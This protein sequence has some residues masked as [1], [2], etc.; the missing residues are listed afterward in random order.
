MTTPERPPRHVARSRRHGARTTLV[1]HWAPPS[2]PAPRRVASLRPIRLEP[3][4]ANGHGN[5]S[6]ADGPSAQGPPG[7]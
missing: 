2:R 3:P 5:G 4:S 6:P 7:D 1:P